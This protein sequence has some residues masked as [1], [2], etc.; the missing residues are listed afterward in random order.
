MKRVLLSLTLALGSAVLLLA[1]TAGIIN[2]RVTDANTGLALEGVRV[3]I[4]DLAIT[5]YTNADGLYTLVNVE[6]GAKTV[7]FSY[8]GYDE[9]E[10]MVEVAGT[11][12]ARL[13]VAFEVLEMDAM[14]I[15]G[16]VVGTARAINAQRASSTLITSW[17]RMKLGVSLIKT[18]RKRCNVF[19]DCRYI[20]TKVKAATSWY[21]VLTMR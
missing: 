19:L 3:R 15:Q 2:G 1:Q 16:A 5:G 12:P 21:A 7:S 9:M 10:R 11:M 20:A 13:D 17:H 8:V 14:V 4:E 6:P 18:R